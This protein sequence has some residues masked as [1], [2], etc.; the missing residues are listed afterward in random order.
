[1]N[2]VENSFQIFEWTGTVAFALAGAMVAVE[3]R[4]DLFGVIF[5]AITTAMGGGI[6]RD[7]LM[8]SFP[9]AF[10]TNHVC[11]ILSTASALAVFLLARCKQNCYQANKELVEQIN[12]IFDAIGLGAFAV[13]GTQ[14]GIEAGF[15][16]NGVFVI[17]LG[18]TTA[19]GGGILRDLFLGEIPFV[20]RKHIYAVASIAGSMCC[21][22]L[23]QEGIS[24]LYSMAWGLLFTFC[25]RLCAIHFQ[26]NLPRAF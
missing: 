23:Y 11:L 1:M 22:I 5:L 9:A 4:M 24:L 12:Q 25:L 15:G 21:Y 18:M 8:G 13:S 6:I 20:L 7:V 14:M 19:V 26:W 10:F 16:A 17:F 2:W 3:K